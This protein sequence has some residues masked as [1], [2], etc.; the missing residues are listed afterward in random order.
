MKI[1]CCLEKTKHSHLTMY[2]TF[3]PSKMLYTIP[4]SAVLLMGK[5]SINVCIANVFCDLAG[6][7]VILH[8]PHD[9]LIIYLVY[10]ALHVFL[11]S[12]YV[13]NAIGDTNI[14]RGGDVISLTLP[15]FCACPKPG[16]LFLKSSQ[17]S[18][19]SMI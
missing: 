14:K 3:P 11:S 16:T 9:Q 19:C 2:M 4:V 13:C 8:F 1:K 12:V 10:H 15:H 6:V 5:S 18:L 17:S 7:I